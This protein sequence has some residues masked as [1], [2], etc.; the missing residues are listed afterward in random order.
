MPKLTFAGE[1]LLHDF[2]MEA[3]GFLERYQRLDDAVLNGEF[4]PARTW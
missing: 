1:P 4:N 2:N 3:D